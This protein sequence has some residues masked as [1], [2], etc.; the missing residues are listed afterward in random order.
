MDNDALIDEFRALNLGIRNISYMLW[1]LLALQAILPRVDH[2]AQAPLVLDLRTPEGQAYARN[3][4]EMMGKLVKFA[5][6]EFSGSGQNEP[7]L[8]WLVM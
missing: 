1:S 6:D 7:P 5:M 4:F 3:A 8:P 2:Q